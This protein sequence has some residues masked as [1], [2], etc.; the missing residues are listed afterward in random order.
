MNLVTVYRV[1]KFKQYDWL[2]KYFN[3]GFNTGKR[4]IVAINFE[5]YFL[6]HMNNSANCKT[7]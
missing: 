7:M 6:K 1:L 5:K 4:K 3:T 2:K